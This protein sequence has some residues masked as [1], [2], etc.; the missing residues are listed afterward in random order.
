M[1]QAAVFGAVMLIFGVMLAVVWRTTNRRAKAKRRAPPPAAQAAQGVPGDPPLL[2]PDPGIPQP[3]PA[4][5]SA[6]DERPYYYNFDDSGSTPYSLSLHRFDDNG[7][8]IGKACDECGQVKWLCDFRPHGTSHDKRTN[9]C[10]ECENALRIRRAEHTLKSV[11]ERLEACRQDPSQC[12]IR[13][14]RQMEQRKDQLEWELEFL[15]HR[16]PQPDPWSQ[17]W[18]ELYRWRRTTQQA[19]ADQ[20]AAPPMT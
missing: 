20:Q 17:H 19:A 2:R 4:S 10:L 13:E 9:T 11:N 16:T 14:L 18:I 8:F 7:E 5:S 1:N 12:T 6:S 15:R 3:K